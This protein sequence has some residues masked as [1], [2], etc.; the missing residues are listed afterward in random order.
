S[1]GQLSS[2][3]LVTKRVESALATVSE[4]N[5]SQVAAELRGAC[6][7]TSLETVLIRFASSS[8]TP[9]RIAAVR[10]L[11]DIATDRG[12]DGIRH[13]AADRTLHH[14]AITALASRESASNLAAL[15]RNENDP[16][17]RRLL[18]TQLLRRDEPG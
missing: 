15:A 10:V 16:G 4:E 13:L 5:A 6:N 18:L 8:E 1:A 7:P 14:V 12:V 11:G 17:L 9:N 2:L 3:P